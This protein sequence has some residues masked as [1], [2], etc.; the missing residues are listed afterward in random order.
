MT[1]TSIAIAIPNTKKNIV[2]QL[3]RNVSEGLLYVDHIKKS[4][5]DKG[6][7]TSNRK[8]VHT[9]WLRVE[10]H[11]KWIDK[12]L[13]NIAPKGS[14]SLETLEMLANIST[15]IV[16]KSNADTSG[17]WPFKVVAANSMYRISKV[18]MLD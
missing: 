4:M 1:L 17:Y 15:N 2:N 18:H 11:H 3:V 16:V 5:E 14:S 12:D 6:S 9:L 8:A 7:T 10:L 13:H